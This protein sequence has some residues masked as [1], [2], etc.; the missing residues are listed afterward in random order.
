MPELHV[1]LSETTKDS[2]VNWQILRVGIPKMNPKKAQKPVRADWHLTVENL[3]PLNHAEVH[4]KPLTVFIGPNSSGK[5]YLAVAI[6]SI[7]CLMDFETIFKRRTI[8][9]GLKKNQDYKRGTRKF[10]LGKTTEGRKQIGEFL[11]SALSS[12]A[13]DKEEIFQN[14]LKKCL[15]DALEDLT[16]S[17]ESSFSDTIEN[18]ITSGHDFID[19]EVKVETVETRIRIS[20]TKTEYIKI[21]MGS[22]TFP[23]ASEDTPDDVLEMLQILEKFATILEDSSVGPSM[24]YRLF[25]DGTIKSARYPSYREIW[26]LPAARGS[27]LQTYHTVTSSLYSG[28]PDA[29]LRRT[30]L[31]VP[32]YPSYAISLFEN[33][34]SLPTEIG[35]LSELADD[36]ER[37]G[38]DGHV[39]VRV[40]PTIDVPEIIFV[41]N[42]RITPWQRV[43][44]GVSE[45]APLVLYV[46]HYIEPGDLLIFEEPEAHLHPR[47]VIEVVKLLVGLVNRKVNVLVTTHSQFFLSALNNHI[48]ASKLK[49]KQRD[50]IGIESLKPDSVSAY[51]FKPCDESNYFCSEFIPIDDEGIGEREF[52]NIHKHLYESASM[53]DYRTSE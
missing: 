28:V 24:L 11:L 52:V 19:I 15:I 16:Y 48:R 21:N 10:L 39:Q 3:G 35:S 38:L 51:L 42:G 43:S 1:R 17:I 36:L 6:D 33:L 4:I 18:L 5:S 23:E 40:K 49:K 34:R 46:R 53:I 47:L 20:P 12:I 14:E 7:C 45:L 2:S 9:R 30:K 41:E 8:S 37:N 29:L 22:I 50:G 44:S 32:K 25:V 13:K 27:Y 31:Q 26:F